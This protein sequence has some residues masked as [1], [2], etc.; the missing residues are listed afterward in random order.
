MSGI[1]SACI[2]EV[3]GHMHFNVTLGGNQ[4]LQMQ[5]FNDCDNVTVTYDAFAQ[6]QP[7]VNKTTPNITIKP[8]TGLIA[9]HQNLMLNIT[10]LMPSNEMVNTS[11][12]GGAAVIETANALNPGGA[13]LE[14]G[15]AK[16]LS[17]TAIAPIYKPLPIILLILVGIGIAVLAGGSVYYLKTK[18]KTEKKPT[19]AQ[20]QARVVKKE[21][22]K[23]AGKVKR[24]ARKQAKNLKNTATRQAGRVRT[25]ARR[26]R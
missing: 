7:N 18:G 17:A 22:K 4:T 24:V 9:P 10:V 16:I 12:S 20:A 19:K 25:Q 5:V 1:S 26:R 14:G 13:Q 2:G 6:L 23:Q 21:A 3:A 11:W 8:K 15:V